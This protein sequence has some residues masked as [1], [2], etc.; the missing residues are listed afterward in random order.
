MIRQHPGEFTTGVYFD[1]YPTFSNYSIGDVFKFKRIN[2][3]NMEQS[4]GTANLENIA[5]TMTIATTWQIPFKVKGYILIQKDLYIITSI[6]H[7]DVQAQAIALVRN[8][9]QRYVIQ[10]TQVDNGKESER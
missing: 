4:I 10:L 5:H 1:K 8:P 2:G 6:A 7:E 9:A 3:Q